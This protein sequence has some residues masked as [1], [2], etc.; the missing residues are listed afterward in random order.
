MTLVKAAAAL[1][2]ANVHDRRVAAAQQEFEVEGSALGHSVFFI[3]YDIH[4][5]S[6]LILLVNVLALDPVV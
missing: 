3:G 6:C 4:Q 1:L 2:D 5:P